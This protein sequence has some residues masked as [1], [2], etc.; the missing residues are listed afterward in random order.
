VELGL[1]VIPNTGDAHSTV[2]SRCEQR[3]GYTGSKTDILARDTLL[4]TDYRSILCASTTL[5]G[6]PTTLLP[7]A[8]NPG[9]R[10]RL[11][12]TSRG[13]LLELPGL[14]SPDWCCRLKLHASGSGSKQ[15]TWHYM[16]RFS[17]FPSVA[18][19]PGGLHRSSSSLGAG[20]N[21]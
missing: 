16:A 11:L 10:L 12:C 17:K 8:A 2:F 4:T 3:T 5:Y 20:W 13:F 21:I 18:P 7:Q 1:R 14:H 6:F 15:K 9:L 19:G